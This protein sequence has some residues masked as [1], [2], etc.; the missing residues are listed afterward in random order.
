MR[1]AKTSTTLKRPL[2]KLVTVENTYQLF[3]VENTYHEANQTGKVREQNLRR[4]AAVIGD[5][6]RGRSFKIYY[7]YTINHLIRFNKTREKI[8]SVAR[9]LNIL[10][11]TAATSASVE[12]TNFKECVALWLATCFRKPKVPSSSPAARYAQR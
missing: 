10:L 8:F 2:N 3:I 9:V 6:E 5:F 1:I 4:E 11:A 7:R 12:K